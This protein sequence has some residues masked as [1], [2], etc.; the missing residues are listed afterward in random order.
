MY[1]LCNVASKPGKVT[2]QED[3]HLRQ[4]DSATDF[5]QLVNDDVSE[6][7]GRRRETDCC[8]CPWWQG[9]TVPDVTVLTVDWSD[10]SRVV[11]SQTSN[12]VTHTPL[13]YNNSEYTVKQSIG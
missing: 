2:S 6:R 8:G 7:V 9:L 11:V 3:F 12:E 5:K 13:G 1:V 10:D 4:A